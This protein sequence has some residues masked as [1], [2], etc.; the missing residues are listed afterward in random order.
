MPGTG[1]EHLDAFDLSLAAAL[2][3]V[4]GAVSMALRV[5]LERKLLWSATRTTVQLLLVGSVLQWVFD[6]SRGRAGAAV[7]VLV[8]SLVMIHLAAREAVQRAA[9][10]FAGA[11]GLTFV[12]LAASSLLVTCLVTGVV[13]RH[14]PWYAPRYFIPL[15]GMILGNGLTGLSLCLDSL[16]DAFAGRR[17]RVEADLALGATSW[18]AAREPVAEAVRRGMIPILNSMAVAGVVSLPGMMT[19]QI[20][21]GSDPMEAVKYQIVVMFMLAAAIALSC[22]TATLLFVRTLFDE[23]HRLRREKIRKG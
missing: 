12:A 3:L 23:R 13:V 16:L 15:L 9:R 19:G 11:R 5:G 20:L 17:E 21:G 22:M 6:P 18:E 7:L 8:L 14:D 2:V 4:A 10:T 1:A